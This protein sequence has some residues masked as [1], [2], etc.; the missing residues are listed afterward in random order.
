MTMMLKKWLQTVFVAEDPMIVV[1][2]DHN[3]NSFN[4]YLLKT[5]YIVINKKK[6]LQV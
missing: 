3:I 4:K 6:T 2:Q 1:D 5:Y